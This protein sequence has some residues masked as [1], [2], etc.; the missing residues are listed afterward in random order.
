MKQEKYNFHDVTMTLTKKD[1]D[2]FFKVELQDK[3]DYYTVV[4]ER[5][6]YDA[7]E[8]AKQWQKDTDKRKQQ[9]ESHSR[10][11]KAMI[12]LDIKNGITP[13]LD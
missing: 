7:C 10:A 13:N 2:E 3:N 12:D 4:Y 8:Y 5:T 6:F 11:V 9:I 1:G